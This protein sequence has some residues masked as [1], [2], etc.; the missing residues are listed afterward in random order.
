MNPCVSSDRWLGEPTSLRLRVEYADSRSTAE[1]TS[2]GQAESPRDAVEL[3]NH[4]DLRHVWRT[5]RILRRPVSSA[6]IR[7]PIPNR[8]SKC[9]NS[10]ILLNL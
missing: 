7:P 5:E 2:T 3:L 4:F 8:T 1:S 10:D 9:F 6:Q